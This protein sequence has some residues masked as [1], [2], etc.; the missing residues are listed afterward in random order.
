MLSVIYK[1]E[2]LELTRDKKT[3]MFMILLPMLIFPAIFG[4]LALFAV[5]TIE[6]SQTRPL[7]YLIIGA[8]SDNPIHQALANASGIQAAKSTVLAENNLPENQLN[9]DSKTW[10]QALKNQSI[11]FVLIINADFE[12]KLKQYQQN[13]WQ[14]HFYNTDG[15][16]AVASRV[17]PIINQLNA[18][19][20]EQTLAEFKLTPIQSQ[21]IIKPIKVE[22]INIAQKKENLGSQLGGFLTYILLPLCLLGAMYPA[23][24]MGAG[25]KERGTLESLIITPVSATEIVLAKYLTICSASFL[26]ALMAILSFMLWGFIFAQGLAIQFVIDLVGTL[27]I[28]DLFFALLMLCPLVFFISAVVLSISIYAKSFKEAQNFMGPLS[29]LVFIPLIVAMLPGIKL[30]WGWAMVPISNVA[31]AVKEILK[32]HAEFGML[33]IIWLSQLGLAAVMLGFCIY[34]FNKESVLFR[35]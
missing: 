6:E 22:Q 18:Q 29:L 4:S 33:S 32:G 31:L 21:A 5:K 17:V 19:L 10:Q 13:I 16:R 1:K 14:L 20:T 24:D 7:N 34:C 35:T 25:E 2:W 12:T 30:S 11:D 23:I 28:S 3:L 8:K 27:G 15:M 26:A 9:S